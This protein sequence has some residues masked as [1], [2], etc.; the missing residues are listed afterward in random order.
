MKDD[1]FMMSVR[2][3]QEIKESLDRYCKEEDRTRAA[4]VRRFISF[5][6]AEWEKVNDSSW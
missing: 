2:L 4:A 3:T 6:L 5:A 1:E